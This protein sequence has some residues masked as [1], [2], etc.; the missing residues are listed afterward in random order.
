MSQAERQLEE[1]FRDFNSN[2][3]GHTFKKLKKTM[4]AAHRL[5]LT[6]ENNTM[7]KIAE[8]LVKLTEAN[9]DLRST[10]ED[11]VTVK[12]L[13]VGGQEVCSLTRVIM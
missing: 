6:A 7:Y 11:N 8:A 10:Y 13:D 9:P 1:A 12:V 5:G 4:D 3:N 2:G